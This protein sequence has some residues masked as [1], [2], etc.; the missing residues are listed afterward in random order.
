MFAGADRFLDKT[1]AGVA[2][3]A[4]AQK[5]T[6]NIATTFSLAIPRHTRLLVNTLAAAI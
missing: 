4:P 5:I 1:L 2:P 3:A 6:F